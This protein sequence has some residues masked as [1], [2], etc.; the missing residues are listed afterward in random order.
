MPCWWK[1]C[2]FRFSVRTGTNI[3]KS[4]LHLRKWVFAVCLFVTNPK[5]TSS[6]KLGHEIT[7]QQRTA[8]FMLHLLRESRAEIGFEEIADPV[9]ADESR[10]FGERKNMSRKRRRELMK[11]SAGRG[12][13]G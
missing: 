10:F 6:T 7:V 9:E 8:W 1:D 4:K 13:S 11:A 12:T 5:G 3:E 2:R